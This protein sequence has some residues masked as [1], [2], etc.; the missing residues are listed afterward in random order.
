MNNI[1]F[2]RSKKFL[3]N[4][5][6]QQKCVVLSETHFLKEKRFHKSNEINI[7]NNSF[8]SFNTIHNSSSF[9]IN[10]DEKNKSILK[11]DSYLIKLDYE[12]STN[13]VNLLKEKQKSNIRNNVVKIDLSQC[14]IENNKAEN[15][16]K[17]FYVDKTI[18][19]TKKIDLRKDN[20][21]S[22][23]IGKNKTNPII[24]KQ[25]IDDFKQISKTKRSRLCSPL[26]KPSKRNDNKSDFNKM[27]LKE[28]MCQKI[29]SNTVKN[30]EITDK[31][32]ATKR[33]GKSLI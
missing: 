12:T 24:I 11:N 21:A 18:I 22:I 28:V 14:Q 10:N 20:E 33:R 2:D 6:N 4:L 23:S 29:L 5:Y 31:V 1:K 3:L 25:E 30:E 9:Q 17:I 15:F 32:K 7:L 19:S 8:C 16:K 26:R 13:Q 27:N